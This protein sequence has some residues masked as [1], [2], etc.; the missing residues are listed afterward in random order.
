V[1]PASLPE[2]LEEEAVGTIAETYTEIRAV[3][4]VPVVN[5]LYRHLAAEPGR[6]ESTWAA[7]RP[8]LAH[9]A[10]RRFAVQLAETADR[11]RPRVASLDRGDLVRSGVRAADLRRAR[12][13]LA[14]YE[15]ANGLNLLAVSGLL[16]GTPGSADTGAAPVSESARSGEILPMADRVSLE[17]PTRAILDQLSAAVARPRDGTLVPSLYRHLASR[18][19]LLRLV[20]EKVGHALTASQLSGAAEIVQEQAAAL[21]GRL[22]RRVDAVSDSNVRRVLE[23]FTPAMALAAGLAR[24]TAACAIS[25]GASTRPSG[26]RRLTAAASRGS[27]RDPAVMGVSVKPGATPLTR[28]PAPAQSIASDLVNAATAPLLEL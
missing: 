1:T 19:A 26:M 14:V 7:L 28:T 25:T 21:A 18:P 16:R 23:R 9:P 4:A 2:I 17:A 20:W 11:A 6:L 3:L 15:R 24:K 27:P 8:N 13:T 22:P 10:T 5:L 12:A